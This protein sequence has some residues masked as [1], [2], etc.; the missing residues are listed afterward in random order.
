MARF[1]KED[2]TDAA[3]AAM[4]EGGTAAINMEQLA[5]QFDVSKGAVYHHFENRDALLAAALERWEETVAADMAAGEGIA[6]PQERL[7]AITM[8]AIGTRLDGFVDIALAS[9]MDNDLVAATVERVNKMRLKYVIDILEALGI[10]EVERE[11]R[12]LGGLASYLGLYQLQRSTRDRFEA[13]Q[14]ER[15]LRG[16]VEQMLRRETG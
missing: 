9:S 1:T 10:P 5:R 13:V 7:T 16:V 6:D 14:M 2:W 15:L 11:E 12:A 3:L 4:A 8:A